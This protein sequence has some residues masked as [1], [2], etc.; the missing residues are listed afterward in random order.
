MNAIDRIALA[1]AEGVLRTA[2]KDA[3][4]PPEA[5]DLVVKQ[6]DAIADAIEAG[7]PIASVA[8]SAE[9]E[10]ADAAADLAE[11]AKFK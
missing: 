6:I 3:G 2:L 5:T 4:F 11:R 1:L 9:L 10:A 8:G 7:K